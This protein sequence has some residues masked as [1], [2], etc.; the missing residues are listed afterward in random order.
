MN[1]IRKS[2]IRQCQVFLSYAAAERVGDSLR[3]TGSQG[4]LGAAFILCFKVLQ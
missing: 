1:E 3:R 2:E 4:P